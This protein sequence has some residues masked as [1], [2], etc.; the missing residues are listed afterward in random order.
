MSRTLEQKEILEII[1]HRYE[2]VLLD[3]IELSEGAETERSGRGQ[4][5]FSTGDE[6]GR[7]IFLV[8]DQA[9]NDI[10]YPYM[11]MEFFALG[12]ITLME[13]KIRG[14]LVAVFSSIRKVSVS[15]TASA[16]NE[17]ISQVAVKGIS[18]GFHRFA[19]TVQ[20]EGGTLSD[21]QIMAYGVDFS[22]DEPAPDSAA[23]QV[24]LPDCTE[25]TD[26]DPQLFAYKSSDLVCADRIRSFSEDEKCIVTEYTYPDSH[27]FVKGHF[28]DNPV[29]MG[30]MQVVTAADCTELLAGRLGRE[31]HTIET[32]SSLIRDDGT[33]VCEIKGLCLSI[34]SQGVF[35]EPKAIKMVA[36]RDMV[37][38]GEK[39]YCRSVVRSA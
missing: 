3:R 15:G 4:V 36:F 21:L 6:K 13:E 1:P 27:P 26:V 31:H 5:N 20:G 39:L 16:G 29:M 24:E 19:G 8:R 7:D 2:N 17:L 28:L 35:P 22:S 18:S 38:P 14:G 32:D 25:E 33:L 10:Y 34:D 23:K 30:I 11:Y 12:A 9:G 37:K